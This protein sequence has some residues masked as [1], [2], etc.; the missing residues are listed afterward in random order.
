MNCFQCAGAEDS[1]PERR[2]LGP[3]PWS[4]DKAVQ[5]TQKMKFLVET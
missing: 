2:P 5:P 1:D 4:P 3:G